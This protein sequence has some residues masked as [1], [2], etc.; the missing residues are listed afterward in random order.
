MATR[1]VDISAAV[2]S[3]MQGRDLGAPAPKEPHGKERLIL[4]AFRIAQGKRDTLKAFFADQGLDFGTGV[5]HVLYDY[6]KRQGI[7]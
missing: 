2:A 4:T 7:R 5:R 6:M 1:K 3:N